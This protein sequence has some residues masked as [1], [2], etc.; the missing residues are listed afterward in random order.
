[1][2]T[3][4]WWLWR[5]CYIFDTSEADALSCA[6]MPRSDAD[7]MAIWNISEF[8]K[9]LGL[10]GSVTSVESDFKYLNEGDARRKCQIDNVACIYRTSEL[11][12]HK[13]QGKYGEDMQMGKTLLKAGK[14]I[15]KTSE[16]KVIHSHNRDAFYYLCRTI[17][18]SCALLNQN[19]MPFPGDILT[20]NNIST[21]SRG[22]VIYSV[23]LLRLLNEMQLPA[24]FKDL[25][26]SI[27]ALNKNIEL[28]FLSAVNELKSYDE[29]LGTNLSNLFNENDV[30]KGNL[31]NHTVGHV[32]FMVLEGIKYYSNIYS[33]ATLE[34]IELLKKFVLQSG[35]IT[36][37]T[38]LANSLV[39][40]MIPKEKR[41]FVNRLIE[42]V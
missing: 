25:E 17:V 29:P 28:S 36:V 15:A 33:L 11:M 3:D 12:K 16:L 2:P 32:E 14:K 35:A 13:F 23:L 34:F 9:F 7:L 42:N 8:N 4:D 27:I 37:G 40:D 10:S 19:F 21:E 5:F 22:A 24:S 38:N 41:E 1:L 26:L 39:M 31:I 20:W 18:D 30:S 6:Q